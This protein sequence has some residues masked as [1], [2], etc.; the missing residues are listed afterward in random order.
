MNGNKFGANKK[1]DSFTQMA[2]MQYERALRAEKRAEKLRAECSD[3]VRGIPK[4][5]MAEYIRIT[6][7]MS[8]NM[9]KWGSV[10]PPKPKGA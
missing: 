9:E 10:R 5:D 4:G 8:E 1:L 6:D 2:I 3:Q 7:E